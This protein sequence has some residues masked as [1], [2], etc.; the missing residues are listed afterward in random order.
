VE[1]FF[2]FFVIWLISRA[3]KRGGGSTDTPS[4]PPRSP[5]RTDPWPQVIPAGV[6]KFP[7]NKWEY[8]HPPPKA[9]IARAKA[10]LQS[11]WDKGEKT[12]KLEKTG[13]RWIVYRAERMASGKKGVVA[14][15]EKSSIAK[16]PPST[17]TPRTP[18][19]SRPPPPPKPR[20]PPPRTDEP[21][22]LVDTTPSIRL[23]PID[24]TYPAGPETIP[25]IP[26]MLPPINLDIPSPT[27]SP[28]APRPLLKRG[29][30]LKPAKPSKAVK[31]AQRLLGI[32]KPDGR[33]GGG[34]AR[35]VRKFQKS[36]G[37]DVDGDIGRET[38]AALYKGMGG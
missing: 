6:P 29:A 31:R 8:D 4:A 22:I 10:L 33:F 7:G 1:L 11:L 32:G 13:H 26:V 18:T 12:W 34:T 14:F 5:P 36:H 28:A 30:G 23:P 35:A 20:K 25:S 15:R 17:P 9:V 27:P 16:R 21:Q 24:M 19:P 2:P 38:W 3:G 37:L